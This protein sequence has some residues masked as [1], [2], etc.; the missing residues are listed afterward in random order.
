M[1]NYTAMP[2]AQQ[3]SMLEQ[4]D[5]NQNLREAKSQMWKHA[6]IDLDDAEA[7]L[8][9][10]T[11]K[12]ETAWTDPGGDTFVAK[13]RDTQSVIRTW[14]Q[15]ISSAN[16]ATMLDQ[17]N[18]LVPQAL[19]L[20]QANQKLFQQYLATQGGVA[21]NLGYSADQLEAP[22]REPSGRLMDQI[23]ALYEQAGDAVTK[24]GSGPKYRGIDDN[25]ASG[26]PSASVRG[27][28]GGGGGAPTGAVSASPGGGAPTGE[29]TDPLGGASPVTG[30][31]G[32]TGQDALAQPDPALSGSLGGSGGGGGA[33]LPT[34]ADAAGGGQDPTLSGG[35]SA[36]PTPSVTSPIGGGAGAGGLGAGPSPIPSLTGGLGGTGGTGA[37]PGGGTGGGGG[38]GTGLGAM[39][40][41]VTNIPG[42]G[43]GGGGG[44]GNGQGGGL[45]G[46]GG[47]GPVAGVRVPGVRL[48]GGAGIP[49]LGSAGG[50]GVGGGGGIGA[51]GG[52]GGG[53]GTGAGQIPA[54][55]TPYEAPASA[56]PGG[57]APTAPTTAGTATAGGAGSGG[58]MGGMPMSPMGMGGMGGG[59]GAPGSGAVSRPSGNNRNRRKEVVTPG[60]PVMLSG[61]AGMADVNAFAGRG[62]RQVQESDVPTTVQ[63]IDEDL[64]QVEQKPAAEEQLVA[65]PVRR[66]H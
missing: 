53:A 60:L 6:V 13:A 23:A 56:G 24:A 29:V 27:G 19:S 20:A 47:G 4:E 50:G 18:A 59:G 1:P 51:V 5:K 8:G 11:D 42:L 10:Q 12:L 17:I 9:R 45:G 64:W 33:D 41:P 44:S 48:G 36:A 25:P 66:A 49:G 7:E 40:T 35:L 46:T 62:R 28:G 63:L 31:D 30:V 39:P 65:P 26:G 32:Q 37:R 38:G 15:N 2:L 3:I 61:K 54:A 52:V 58:G 21:I 55:A 34:G 16:P 43:T 14:T 22:Y 57:V